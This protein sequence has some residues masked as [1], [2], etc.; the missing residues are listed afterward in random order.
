MPGAR[1]AGQAQLGAP[2]A[3][4]APEEGQLVPPL[5]RAQGAGRR[6]EVRRRGIVRDRPQRRDRLRQLGARQGREHPLGEPE[7][8]RPQRR[9]FLRRRL[10]GLRHRDTTDWIGTS[11]TSMRRF[12]RRD[13]SSALGTRGCSAPKPATTRVAGRPAAVRTR[14][15]ARAR[16][17]ESS[18]FEA[19][20]PPPQWA[21]VGVAPDKHHLVAL[22]LEQGHEGRRQPSDERVA[23]RAQL[24]RAPVEED[25]TL[26]DDLA[27]LD[28][29]GDERSLEDRLI[30]GRFRS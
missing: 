10:G 21:I 15:T 30:N 16:A 24:I 27:L 19:K 20:R 2:D 5:T 23:F 8:R 29:D 14:V 17:V 3:D 12:F 4:G 25:L 18:Q 26:K 9:P 22:G 6:Q 7:Q 28:L 1:Q 13:A 11:S